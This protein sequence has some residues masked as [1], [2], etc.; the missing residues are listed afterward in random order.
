VQGA[1]LSR[2]AM[3]QAAVQR[4]HLRIRLPRALRYSGSAMI[5][6]RAGRRR[7]A[8]LRCGSGTAGEPY[9][10]KV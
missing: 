7:L 3:H 8:R 6:R 10:R 5:I 2:V 1:R 4:R 9:P